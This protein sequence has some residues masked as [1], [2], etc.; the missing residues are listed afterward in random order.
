MSDIKEFW[1]IMNILDNAD[2]VAIFVVSFDFETVISSP[3]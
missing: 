2:D 1:G 3:G